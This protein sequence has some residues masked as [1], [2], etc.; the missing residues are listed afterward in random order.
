MSA[1]SSSMSARHPHAAAHELC[2]DYNDPAL[3]EPAPSERVSPRGWERLGS[4]IRSL[5]LRRGLALRH[6][7]G[8]EWANGS[9]RACTTF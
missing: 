5:S 9:F 8:L 1:I 7:S 6:R 3:V 4:S 2:P